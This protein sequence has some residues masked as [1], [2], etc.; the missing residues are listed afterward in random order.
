MYVIVRGVVVSSCIIIINVYAILVVGPVLSV[1]C[2]VRIARCWWF[3]SFI[4]SSSVS[5]S[6][7]IFVVYCCIVVF[8][9]SVLHLLVLHRYRRCT[10]C[11][12]V[13]PRVVVLFIAGTMLFY[14][15][16][17]I[18]FSCR[19]LSLWCVGLCVLVV[20]QSGSIS[21]QFHF[22]PFPFSVPSTF[23]ACLLCSTHV[24]F[25]VPSSHSIPSSLSSLVLHAYF[26]L[27]ALVLSFFLH[28][29]SFVLPPVL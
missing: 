19:V 20:R 29:T 22:I 4:I 10:P 15:C 12:S 26:P 8:C 24:S 5:C 2:I 11:A 7:G 21:F 6:L 18:L 14:F 13:N 3:L 9:C 28:F 23:Y 17:G 25:S 16:F 27:T 1:N